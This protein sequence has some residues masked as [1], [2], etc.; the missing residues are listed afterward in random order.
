M[1]NRVLAT[2]GNQQITEEDVA[3]FIA[4]LGERGA[5]YSSPEGRKAIL[6]ELIAQRLFYLEAC[7]NLYEAEPEFK[8]QL[9]RAKENLLT[10]YAI[11]RALRSVT[12]KDDEVR[13]Y[14]D[15]HKDELRDEG[16]MS[17]S[18]I[19]VD[20]EEQAQ[21]ILAKIR[22]GSISFE[23]AAKQY[24]SC[25]SREQGGAL[26]SFGHGQMVPEFEEACLGMEVGA[27]SEPVKTRFG[28]H[29]IRLDG[30]AE[31]AEIP[32]EEI[33]DRLRARLLAEKQQATYR[34]KVNQLS[35]LFPVTRL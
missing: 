2:V 25:P 32:Y 29:I 15:A 1:E 9:K 34:S 33:R 24:S 17:A 23:D 19:L 31:P 35:I 18:H 4:S 28:Y 5:Q 26:G 16:S 6:E 14:Y 20:S 7:R 27:I 3:S 8:A 21:D 30:K 10:G 13:A 11:D 22:G 12:V